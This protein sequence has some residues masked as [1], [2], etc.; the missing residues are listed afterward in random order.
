MLLRSLRAKYDRGSSRTFGNKMNES[1][2]F[3]LFALLAVMVFVWFGL[4]TW[5]FRRLEK[6]HPEKYLEMGRPSL[7]L[8]NNLENNWLFMKF[9]WRSDYQALNDLPL[10]RTCSVMKVFLCIYCLL[11]VSMFFLFFT[12]MPQSK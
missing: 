11:F 10:T 2:Y 4:C 8:R 6:S 5:T 3:T 9:M 12:S 1:F 7:F